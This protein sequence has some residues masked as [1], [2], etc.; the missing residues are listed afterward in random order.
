MQDKDGAQAQDIAFGNLLLLAVVLFGDTKA[1]MRRGQKC[2]LGGV[3]QNTCSHVQV[4]CRRYHIA[5]RWMA[6]IVFIM[7]SQCK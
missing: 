7:D 5:S 6:Y 3:G 1:K 4:C 2:V